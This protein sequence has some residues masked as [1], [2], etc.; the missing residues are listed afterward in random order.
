MICAPKGFCVLPS[1]GNAKALCS[2]VIP[3]GAPFFHIIHMLRGS[4]TVSGEGHF[5]SK[6]LMSEGG[7]VT[8]CL[9]PMSPKWLLFPVGMVHMDT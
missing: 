7:S 4:E 5:W 1:L 2:I 3:L 6:I 9:P 8:D